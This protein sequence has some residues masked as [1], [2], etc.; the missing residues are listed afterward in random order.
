MRL[1]ADMDYVPAAA[2][3]AADNRLEAE[4]DTWPAV[5]T[6][7]ELQPVVAVVQAGRPVLVDMQLQLVV[8]VHDAAVLVVLLLVADSRLVQVSAV[9]IPSVS[10]WLRQVQ[11]EDI[12]CSALR[13][14][15]NS[16]R[17]M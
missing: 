3:A 14:L 7:V 13:A 12:Q 9:D 4:L 17:A 5:H 10:D 15:V 8:V 6:T 16:D 1:L 11:P 2:V